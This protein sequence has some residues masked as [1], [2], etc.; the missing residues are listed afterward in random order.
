MTIDLSKAPYLDRFDKEKSYQQVLFNPDRPLQQSELNE[1]QSITKNRITDIGNA[2][3]KDGDRQ[4]GAEINFTADY[5]DGKYHYAGTIS[6]GT[7]YLAGAIRQVPK[8]PFDY[9]GTGRTHYIGVRI[10][11]ELVTSTEDATLLDQTSGVA[12]AF[13]A[14]ADRLKETVEITFDDGS[15]A[16]LYN[17][18]GV[19][20]LVQAPDNTMSQINKV[21]AERTYDESGSYKVSGFK[22][23]TDVMTE[24]YDEL[25]ENGEATRTRTPEDS[26]QLIVDGGK[27]Y[28][29]G[30]QVYKP[31]GVRTHIDKAMTFKSI[32]NES[33]YYDAKTQ[34]VPLANAGVKSVDNVSA[35]VSISQETVARGTSANGTDF[36]K[37]NSVTR[38][39]KVY[40]SDKTYVEGTDWK[41]KDGQ[42]VSWEADGEEPPV[43]T[44]YF[45]DYTYTKIMAKGVDYKVSNDGTGDSAVTYIDFNGMSGVKPVDQTIMF[46]N[47]THYL[48]RIDLVV[49]D[50]D[51]NFIVKAGQPDILRKVAPPNHLDPL[52]LRIATI[53][54]YPNSDT[55]VAT[56]VAIERLSMEDLGKMRTRVE[57]LEYNQAINYLDKAA[58]DNENPVYLRGVFSDG[59]LSLEKYD[60]TNPDA[61]IAFSFEDG[62][63]TLPYTSTSK[64][65]PSLLQDEKLQHLWGRLVTAPFTE[66]PSITQLQATEAMNVNPYAVYSKMGTLQ[67]SPSADNWISE[68]KITVN[69]T[70]TTSMT[71]PM[72]WNHTSESW[73]ASAAQKYS[74]IV[75]DNGAV[76]GNSMGSNAFNGTITTNAG[77][78]TKQSMIEYMRELEV[79]F[80]AQN[81][82]FNANN[83]ELT[84]DGVHVNVTPL[85]GYRKGGDAGTAMANAD[86]TFKGKFTIPGGIRCGTR[87]VM[88]ANKDC[89]AST[90]FVA[91]GTLKTT[92][93]TILRTRV[94]ISY[95]D[96]LAQ[97]FSFTTARVVSSLGL[98][99][100]SKSATDGLIVQVRGVT[101]GGQP[102]K[103][104]YAESTMTA[105]QIKV[106]DDSSAQT[107]VL[108]DDPLMCDA[109]VEYCIVIITDSNEYTMWIATMGQDLID[110]PST[111]VTANPYTTGVLYSSSN[112]S[113]WT[114]HQSSDLKF[115]IYTASFNETAT[116]EFDTIQNM[117]SDT[118]VLLS[119]YLT[120]DSTGCAWEAKI[121]MDNEAT[122]ITVDNKSWEPIANY[123]TLE[124]DEI[125]REVKLRATFKANKYMSPLLSLEDMLFVGFTTALEGSYISRTIDLADAPF[126]NIKLQYDAFLPTGT[127]VTPKWSKDGGNTWTK[128]TTSPTIK[129]AG[130]LGFNT[131]KYNETV[132]TGTDTFNSFKIRLDM[133]TANSFSRPRVRTLLSTMKEN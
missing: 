36:V 82:P 119:T 45:V 42:S 127:S 67:L 77:T 62:E 35:S 108:F 112:A 25:D 115:V 83:L 51:G 40:T 111:T 61:K 109:N 34:K 60:A 7:V 23:Y 2:I 11:Q 104:I 44:T 20:L 71:L 3:F 86:G 30:Y 46:T 16:P 68:D 55:T 76:F 29:L 5:T 14:G 97:S 85:D 28:V 49:L 31:T 56:D 81:L 17:F 48:A 21:L 90:T 126:N 129:S 128:F 87:E 59:F 63:I 88:L 9:T 94:S 72:W 98:Y 100:A 101:E 99:F 105:S 120:P 19:D 54:I 53:L 47:Y 117:K 118:V 33:V 13:S 73:A 43:G 116:M 122:N 113:A 121:V 89:T 24:N 70:D 22:C 74:N 92:T 27:A 131:F 84:F 37:N 96:P 1:V 41:L 10:K 130:T 32:L 52:T 64:T 91:Q 114:I 4:D 125:V 95:Q 123:A 93:E 6:A 79:S 78:S 133:L 102:N 15:S 69:T 124:A 26:L 75:L 38:I 103:T 65:I 57:D 50:A 39:S 58:M 80:T 132:T 18:D 106:S 8:T 110:D 66:E 107:K 12:S